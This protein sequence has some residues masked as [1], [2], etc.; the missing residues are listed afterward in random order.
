MSLIPGNV[1]GCV[2]FHHRGTKCT[3]LHGVISV[4]LCALSASVVKKFRC[5]LS[6]FFTILNSPPQLRLRVFACNYCL[7]KAPRRNYRRVDTTKNPA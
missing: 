1:S 2:F 6:R 7:A 3:E 4:N 5:F